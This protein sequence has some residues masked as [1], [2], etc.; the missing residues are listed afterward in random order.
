M[1]PVEQPPAVEPVDDDFPLHLT[2][3]RTAMQYQSGAQTRRVPELVAATPRA[4]VELHPHL[5]EQLGVLDGERVRVST[6]RGQAWLRA[7]VSDAIRADTVFVPFHWAGKQR[8]NSLTSAALDPVSGMPSF[9]L[10][11]ARIDRVAEA[12]R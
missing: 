5:A 7:R 10:C 1:H 2:T 3:G 4:F 8:A 9:K 11:A 6:R 12:V